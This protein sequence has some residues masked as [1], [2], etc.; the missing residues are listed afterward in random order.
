MKKSINEVAGT[1]TF[2]FDDELEPVV[3]DVAKASEATRAY[4]TLHGFMARIGDAAA[5]Q[6]NTENNFR[7]TDAMRKEAVVEMVEHYHSGTDQ[8]SVRAPG[9]PKQSKQ[10]PVILAIAAKRNCSYEE[11]EKW[12]AEKMLAELGA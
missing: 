12:V 4:A 2:S 8:W 9:K 11:A 10:S 1:I 7:V 6:K 3:F 5:I